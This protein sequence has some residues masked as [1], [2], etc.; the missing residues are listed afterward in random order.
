M[1]TFHF[2]VHTQHNTLT[3]L[4]RV[5]GGNTNCTNLLRAV[6]F[7]KVVNSV[8]AN[9]IL[10]ILWQSYLITDGL[11][12]LTRQLY[13]HNDMQSLIDTYTIK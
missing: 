13:E 2:Y 4:K 8:S 1:L 6:V 5:G 7:L 11:P 10:L 9:T 3:H 12:C